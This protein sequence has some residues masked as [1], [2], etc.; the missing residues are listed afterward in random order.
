MDAERRLEALAVGDV[1][2]LLHIDRR[3]VYRLIERGELHG[4]RVGRVWRV[5]RLALE[6]FL[7]GRGRRRS[8]EP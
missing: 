6:E 2:A 8:A 7:T 4:V 1:A 5:P 3:T